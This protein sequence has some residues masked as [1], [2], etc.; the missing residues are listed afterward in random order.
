MKLRFGGVSLGGGEGGELSLGA[1]LS[2]AADDLD[3][4]LGLVVAGGD[5]GALDLRGLVCAH[6]GTIPKFDGVPLQKYL[7]YSPP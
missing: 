5:R 1:A 7:V 2:A 3:C 4:L 6:S